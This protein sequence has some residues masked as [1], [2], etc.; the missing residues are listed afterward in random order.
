MEIFKSI[1]P[2]TG[3]QLPSFNAHS[4]SEI[5]RRVDAA[6]GAFLEWSLL[7]YSQR[8]KYLV[9]ISELLFERKEELAYLCAIEMGKPI[10]QGI[11]EVEKCAGVCRYYAENA[12][13]MLEDEIIK[14]SLS[15][16]YITYQPLGVILAIMPWNFPFWQVLRF[17]APAL[18]AGNTVIL[19]HAP[20][21]FG[22][23][24]AIEKIFNDAGLP[25]CSLVNIHAEIRH[26]PAVIKNN[27][28]QGVTFTGSTVAGKKIARMSG[29]ALKKTVME[30][31]GSDAYIILEDADLEEA[32]KTCVTSRCINTGQSCISA[33]RFIVVRSVLS[34]V[35][36]LFEKMLS[37]KTYGNPLE[38]KFDLGPL[39][40]FDLRDK[41][42][43]Q[44]QASVQGGATC[45]LGG[46]IPKGKGAFYSPT[47]LTNVGKGMAAYNEELFGPVASI[48]AADDEA[49][50]IRIANDSE[51]GLGSAIFTKD[52]ERGE[53]IARTM[54]QAGTCYVNDFVKSD[55]RLPFGGIKNSGFGR[56]LSVA[57]IQEFVNIKTV[58]V[59]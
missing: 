48:I 56:E 28:I 47:L 55:A 26:I 38:G 46:A 4:P 39:A 36:K 20:I 45:V 54:I 7:S 33:K 12:E 41:L 23:A 58:G 34:K 30:L 40:R 29:G 8:A 31:G 49:D 22:C 51:Y 17:A 19:K 59:K 43:S 37:E 3:E 50:A 25:A 57:G 21:T 10:E 5:S 13:K 2:S 27:K 1:N 42:H 32:V 24:L 11:A 44:V 15:K 9:R 14:S 35:E 53:R 16:S 18:M 6:H 52:I